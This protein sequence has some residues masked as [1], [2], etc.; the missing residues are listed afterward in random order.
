[1]SGDEREWWPT[2]RDRKNK[3]KKDA[4][5]KKGSMSS[6]AFVASNTLSASEGRKP[7]TGNA[8][9]EFDSKWRDVNANL[10]AQKTPP[11]ALAE[12]NG[13]RLYTGPVR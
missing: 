7:L 2:N 11:L 10:I 8:K 9:I 1:M 12:V 13:G 5:K 6:G 3:A 4:D